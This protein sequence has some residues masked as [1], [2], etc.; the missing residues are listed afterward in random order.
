MEFLTIHTFTAEPEAI[1]QYPDYL[2]GL[3]WK[4]GVGLLEAEAETWDKPI[5]W[6]F[7]AKKDE[8][9][10]LLWQC[11]PHKFRPCLASF[12]Q[13]V[14]ISPYGGHTFF[15][16]EF[17]EEAGGDSANFSLFLSNMGPSGYWL[18]LY[19][20]TTQIISKLPAVLPNDEVS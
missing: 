2:I 8:A 4:K 1:Y 15:Q 13:R 20:Y 7:R 14:G 19:M 10:E 11:Q 18:K 5:N 3:L 6:C 16:V 9:S 17:Y 12:A